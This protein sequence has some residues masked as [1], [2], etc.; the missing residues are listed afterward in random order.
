[1][2]KLIES[3]KVVLYALKKL[4]L[5]GIDA[6]RDI[7]GGNL[8]FSIDR[9]LQPQQL[10]DFI[11]QHGVEPLSQAVQI[12]EVSVLNIES[13]SSN[14]NNTLISVNTENNTELYGQ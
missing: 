12:T 1:M 11:N 5:I 13:I 4:V 6:T 10:S 2:M 7:F 8:T 14:C 9:F 3:F